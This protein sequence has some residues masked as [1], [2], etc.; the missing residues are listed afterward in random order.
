MQGLYLEVNIHEVIFDDTIRQGKELLGKSELGNYADTLKTAL[1]NLQKRWDSLVERT[2]ERQEQLDEVA[3][4]AQ[5]YTEDMENFTPAL[6]EMEEIVS[7]C[8]EV[9]CEKHALVRERA[10][11]KVTFYTIN[12]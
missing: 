2:N 11:L 10:F 1:E 6:T 8:G 5:T 4:P 12:L 9:F 3:P 7:D